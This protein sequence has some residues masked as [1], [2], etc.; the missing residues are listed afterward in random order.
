MV[1]GV[2]ALAIRLD[3]NY[4]ETA[5]RIGQ[6]IQERR[7][8]A[9]SGGIFVPSSKSAVRSSRLPQPPWLGGVGPFAWRQAIQAFRGSRGP[10][11]LAVI[12]VVAFGAPLAFGAG[13][14]NGLPGLL[15]HVIVGM[16]AYVTFIFSAQAPLGFR[17]DYERM[18]LL[19]SLPIRPVAIA[20]GQT[21]VIAL[22]LTALQWMVFAATAILVPAAAAEMLVAG[23]FILPYN[24]ILCGTEN[25]LFLLYPS[26]LA[27]N[28]ADGFL[29]MGRVMLV[30]M[31]KFIMITACGTVAAIPA[32][33]AFLA[34]R[35]LLLAGL[36]GWLALLFPATGI[37]LLTAWAFRRYDVSVGGSE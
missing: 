37:L 5:V 21:L 16:S 31:A 35:N 25:F 19:K 28:S 17:G 13:R 30:M 29:R 4:L 23:L 2:Y 10:I 36:V 9:M 20:C 34:S 8:R 15:P 27:A 6:Q 33:V 7:R 32:V 24:W 26:P 14:Q 1:V 18:E 12:M 3:A 11:L 22:I